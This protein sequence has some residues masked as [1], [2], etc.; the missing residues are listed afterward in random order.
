M[1]QHRLWLA[2]PALAFLGAC[3][4]D[5]DD[6]PGNSAPRITSAPV[7][8]ATVGQPYRYQVVAVGEPAPTLSVV[9]PAWLSLEGTILQGTPG[10]GDV[11]QAEVTLTASNG[12]EPSAV[13]AFRITVVTESAGNAPAITSTPPTEALVGTP[14]EYTITV[15]GEPTPILT[16]AGAGG[17]ALPGWLSLQGAVLRGT[18]AAGDVGEVGVVLVATNGVEPD[19][20]QSFTITVRADG[21]APAFTSTPVTQATV[22]QAYQYGLTA[23]GMPAP[24]FAL[25]SGP[26]WLA[27]EGSTLRGTP[28]EAGTFPV[29]VT[30][31]N[32]VAPVAEQR[33]SITV[34]ATGVAPAITSTPVATATVGQAYSYTVVA[35]GEPA[36]TISATGAAGAALPA[37]LSF[38]GGQL[39]GT[40]GENDVGA[41]SV[42]VT[43]SNG[44]SPDATQSFTIAVAPAQVAPV[45][46]SQPVTTATVGAPYTYT[47]AATGQPAPTLAAGAALPAWLSFDAAT[48]VLSGTPAATDVGNAAVTL[49]ASN[50]VSPD[51]TQ[52]FTIAVAPPPVAPSITSTP[53][54]VATAG[55]A[56]SYTVVA[57]G[58]PAPTLA[59]RGASGAVLP[60]WLSFDAATGVLSGT[61]AATDVGTASVVVTASNG[62]SPDATQ[63]FTI[64]VSAASVAPAI[65]STA[66]TT[67]QVGVAYSYTVVAT[68]N[69]APTITVA[70]LPAWLTFDGTATISGTPAA[71]DVGTAGPITVTATGFGNP[72][73]QTFSITVAPAGAI[74]V[75][76]TVFR[77]DFG[78]ALPAGWSAT[79]LWEFGLPTTGAATV[80]PPDLWDGELAA[81]NLTGPYGN[82]A[83]Y[84][85]Q[86]PTF[87]LTGVTA[88][89][90]RFAHWHNFE[91]TS[92]LYDGGNL[93]ISSD[94]GTTWRQLVPGSVTPAY[95]GTMFASTTLIGGQL[96]W[97]GIS[98]NWT[99][100]S[101]DLAAN[102][103]GEPLTQ[104]ALR[105]DVGSDSSAVRP[106]WYVDA[107]RLGAA[108]DIPAP[109][110]LVSTAA[111]AQISAGQVYTA[112]VSA[113]GNPAPT[114]TATTT[115]GPLPAWLS[116]DP[117]TGTL[118]GTPSNSDA[119]PVTIVIRADNGE[120]RAAVLSFTLTVV[121]VNAVAEFDFE[122]SVNTASTEATNVT[123]GPMTTR[124]GVTTYPVGVGGGANRALSSNGFNDAANPNAFEF[125]VTP[126]VGFA[127]GPTGLSFQ[128]QRS[129]TGPTS[130]T[131]S[132]LYLGTEIPV[133]GGTLS[134]T[135]FG[136]SSVSFSGPAA[137]PF[138][139]SFTVRI[140]ASGANSAAGTW[141]L[142]DV[143]LDGTVPPRLVVPVV[144][145]T[146][147]VE[148]FGSAVPAGWA[149]SGDWDFGTPTTGAAAVGPPSVFD[150]AVA[151]TNIAGNYSNSTLSVLQTPVLDL[152]GVT[153]PR[154]DFQHWHNFETSF[155]GANIKIST[156]G[157]ST[158]RPLVAMSFTPDYNSTLS[159]ASRLPG[160]RAWSGILTDWTLVVVDLAANLAGEPVNRVMLR[161][162][163]GSDGSVVWPGWYI[164]DVRIGAASDLTMMPRVIAAVGGQQAAGRA[165]GLLDHPVTGRFGASGP[166]SLR[167]GGLSS[168]GPAGGAGW[169]DVAGDVR[170]VFFE[171]F[172]GAAEGWKIGFD[173]GTDTD[174]AI[175]TPSG[176]GPLEARSGLRCAATG[177]GAPYAEEARLS[178]LETPVLDLSDLSDPVLRFA[179]W[180]GAEVGRDG[181]NLKIS[182]DG[183]QTFS[184]VLIEGETLGG[185]GPLAGQVVF[186]GPT[187][188]WVEVEV[189]LAGDLDG[190]PRDRVMLRFEFGSDSEVSGPGWYIDDVLVGD[191]LR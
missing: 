85:M 17:A 22:G 154:L 58:Q 106:G 124:N 75:A 153:A 115:T 86:T 71:G 48:G 11:G 119:G 4:G 8:A 20:T 33:F 13:Q 177:L 76:G 104:V 65:T 97:S 135:V 159:T 89:T 137:G 35:T 80:G 36:P 178:Y 140:A 60:A 172:E 157:G 21:T 151:A 180:Y 10:A 54:T 26:M 28:T 87:D 1:R 67:A 102:L 117:A 170:P 90:L 116:F 152:T 160:Q 66:T 165:L 55:Q 98:P 78:T 161:F 147:F 30:A 139:R 108:A 44:V 181:G 56:Y 173:A 191:R 37:W 94:G 107:I 131:V 51:A 132:I 16:A 136:P 2:L 29:V 138:V 103:V 134:G 43:A 144:N 53:V 15:T 19:A 99:L 127:V 49:T 166:A 167:L 14:Y 163:A 169:A 126:T 46:T 34:A 64:T 184:P 3:G 122:G 168:A 113:A 79:G 186:T 158:F 77:E 7:A 31:S 59:A 189:E 190:L 185:D 188:G 81:T 70:G 63:T 68:G 74:P 130:F 96:A 25:G 41:V 179:H 174:W 69:P 84:Q 110:S 5:D 128:S 129:G 149:S 45:F 93:K 156:D 145:G 6:G 105:F 155:D 101:V 50:G 125:T 183:G 52:S 164:D 150:G 24:T 62:V 118:T 176:E 83:S 148:G 146:P 38:A 42:V 39:S 120:P 18:P 23:S 27:L 142:D 9:G 95:T 32:G 112:S 12:V 111:D 141:R 123:V 92:T 133:G 72:A 182:T 175:G 88:P 40:P 187:D 100:V 121:A 171:D 109:P 114:L 47:A 91:G 61:P 143:R 73:I 57:T 162:E 82:N